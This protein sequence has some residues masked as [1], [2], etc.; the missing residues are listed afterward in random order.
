MYCRDADPVPTV[1]SLYPDTGNAGIT[2]IVTGTGFR[3]GMSALLGGVPC[4]DVTVVRVLS[5]RGVGRWAEQ[6]DG[7]CG[8]IELAQKSKETMAE[9]VI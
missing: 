3:A 8:A 2:A 5:R 7:V 9:K 6:W 4:P 1:V